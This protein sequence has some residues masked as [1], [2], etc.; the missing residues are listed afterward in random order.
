VT[1]QGP[2]GG[3]EVLRLQRTAGNRAVARL[4]PAA[5]WLPAE[6]GRLPRARR[7]VNARLDALPRTTVAGQP[8]FRVAIWSASAGAVAAGTAV[9]PTAGVGAAT[10]L[11]AAAVVVAVVVAALLV[12]RLPSYAL[13]AAVFAGAVIAAAVLGVDA[14]ALLDAVAVGLAAGQA[15]GRVGCAMAGC[16]HGRPCAWGH[17]YGAAFPWVSGLRVAPVQ[18][19]EAASCAGLAAAGALVIASGAAAGTAFAALAVGYAAGRFVLEELRGDAGRRYRAGLSDAQWIAAGV[20]AAI[21]ALSAAGALPLAPLHAA[22]AGAVAVAAWAV[23]RDG[24]ARALR[25]L[26]GAGLIEAPGGL[27]LSAAPV[28]GAWTYG[29][30]RPGRPLTPAEACAI[31]RRV[32]R[33]RHADAGGLLLP[34][35]PFVL[36]ATEEEP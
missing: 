18:L 34:G 28:A 14:P 13:Q 4:A 24:T 7:A 20:T 16:C 5:V 25:R 19:L 36:I 1:A 26:D 17:R 22:L 29:I 35:P 10:F 8:A 23:A 9:A 30:S 32:L 11:A 3:P 6:P 21:V 31:A 15:V 2:L 12:H 27:R 33:L